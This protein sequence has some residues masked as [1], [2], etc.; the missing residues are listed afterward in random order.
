[1][2]RLLD[3]LLDEWTEQS[4]CNASGDAICDEDKPAAMCPH[5]KVRHHLLAAYHTIG[6]TLATIKT[7]DR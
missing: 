7:V 2:R 5:C 1:M 4:T 3:H 6:D